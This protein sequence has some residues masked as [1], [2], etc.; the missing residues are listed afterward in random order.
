MTILIILGREDSESEW[1]FVTEAKLR[2]V[3]DPIKAAR[4]LADDGH[5]DKAQYNIH[6]I[7]VSDVDR[8]VISTDV[9][10]GDSDE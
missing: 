4:K 1:K 5:F 7:L 10:N 3:D 2:T 8:R 9:L 6:R